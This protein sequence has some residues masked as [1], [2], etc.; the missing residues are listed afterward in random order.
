MPVTNTALRA[1]NSYVGVTAIT[2]FAFYSSHMHMSLFLIGIG[3]MLHKINS[4]VSVV[5]I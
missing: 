2:S 4:V 1:L 3:K 5:L